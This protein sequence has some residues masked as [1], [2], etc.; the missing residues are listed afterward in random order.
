[1]SEMLKHI[2]RLFKNIFLS[3]CS[4]VQIIYSSAESKDYCAD[5]EFSV[6]S[7]PRQISNLNM[8]FTANED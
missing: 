6:N 5:T 3:T 1:M 7:H 2:L 4:S 8:M